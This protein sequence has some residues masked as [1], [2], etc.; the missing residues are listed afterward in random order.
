MS[1]SNKNMIIFELFT[2]QQNAAV[3]L[4]LI[5]DLFR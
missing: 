5:K 3:L 1:L 2:F 4:D